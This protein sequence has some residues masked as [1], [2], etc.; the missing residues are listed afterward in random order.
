MDGAPDGSQYW[1]CSTRGSRAC[2]QL[3]GQQAEAAWYLLLRY[4][5]A[6]CAPAF[7]AAHAFVSLS[8]SSSNRNCSCERSSSSAT[9]ARPTARP[10]SSSHSSCRWCGRVQC[11]RGWHITVQQDGHQWVCLVCSTTIGIHAARGSRH[12]ITPAN[13]PHAS[14]CASLAVRKE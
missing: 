6:V 7:I 13:V 4:V 8:P 9:P 10:L 12:I 1:P 14:L 5:C 11:I 3:S 2:G